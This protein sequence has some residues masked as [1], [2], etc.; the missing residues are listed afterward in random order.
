M[1]NLKDIFSG[2]YQLVA[3]KLTPYKCPVCD[4][5]GHTDEDVMIRLVKNKGEPVKVYDCHA[6]EGKGIVWG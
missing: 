1:R 5:T 2:D 6:C 3:T 4:G